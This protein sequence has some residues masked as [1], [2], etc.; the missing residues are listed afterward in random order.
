MTKAALQASEPA[1]VGHMQAQDKAPTT[2]GRAYEG[3]ELELIT[4]TTI[5]QIMICCETSTQHLLC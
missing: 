1:K 3:R 5:R 4:V 2:E